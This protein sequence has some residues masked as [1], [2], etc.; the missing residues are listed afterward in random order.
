MKGKKFKAA[1]HREEFL[2]DETLQRLGFTV[3][4][5]S[6]GF[7]VWRI[8]IPYYYKTIQI[9]INPDLPRTNPNCGVFSLFTPQETI[10]G[11]N[12]QGEPEQLT[13]PEQTTNVAWYVDTCERLYTLI[14]TITH[15]NLY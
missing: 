9:R 2:T 3:A 8:K 12:A 15:V 11:V 6:M 4:V 5:D 13:T 1:F 14:Q 7:Q 10:D